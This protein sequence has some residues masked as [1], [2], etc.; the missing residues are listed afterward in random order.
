MTAPPSVLALIESPVQLL[1]LLEWRH[2]R[3]AGTAQV[4]VL[5][6]KQ[7]H[8]RSQISAV[9]A[10]A[11]PTELTVSWLD[12]RLSRGALLRSLLQLRRLVSRVD[13][14][15]VGDPFSGLIQALL[16]SVRA[17]RVIVLDDGTATIDFVNLLES[18]GPLLRWAGQPNRP[19]RSLRRPL[20]NRATRF[21]T[22]RSGRAL[23]LFTV[24]PVSPSLEVEVTRH[25]YEWTRQTFGP[26][27]LNGTVT[28]VGSSLVES[29]ILRHDAYLAAI[30]AAIA[31]E[32][33]EGLYFAHRN[34]SSRKLR[35]VAERTGMRI[36]QLAFPLEIELCRGPVGSR[37]V[38]FPST[39]AYSLPHILRGTGAQVQVVDIQASW[40]RPDAGPRATEFLESI[41]AELSARQEIEPPPE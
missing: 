2:R 3:R 10:L 33:T 8:A 22:P 19:D 35:S 5:A 28:V 17:S 41:G 16:P 34:E 29:G 36:V 15:I 32:H 20:A 39:P 7:G 18:R 21:F 30:E 27:K 9:A 1:H 25:T 24:M 38:C 31:G 40:L 4:V 12:P 11:G 26:P 13:E 23:E 6:P 14:L 37:V